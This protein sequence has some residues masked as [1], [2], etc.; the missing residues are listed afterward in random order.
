MG[1]GDRGLIDALRDA[2]GR[3]PE[4]AELRR[5]LAET[6]L[7]SGDAPAALEHARHLLG[8]DPGNVVVLDIAARAARAAGDEEAAARYAA[9]LGMQQPPA[10]RP[11]PVE[12]PRAH[13]VPVDGGD[14][15]EDEDEDDDDEPWF[16]AERPTV[17]L[18]DVG[19]MEAVKRRLQLSFLG[20]LSNP[21]LREQ[22]GAQLRGGLLLWGPPGCGKTLIARALAGE[23]GASFVSIGISDVLEMWV[24]RSEQNLRA[25]F[26]HARR[27]SPCVIFLDELDAL[28][29]K[30]SQLRH[31]GVRTTVNQLLAELDGAD[32]DND[33]LFVL[34][35]TNHPWDVDTALRRPGRFDRSVLVL[36]PDEAARVAIL[37]GALA[38]RPVASDVDVDE[39]ARR[40]ELC[41][42]ADLVHLVD[43]A[44][45]RA[46]ERAVDSGIVDPISR[47]DLRAAAKD[48]RPS[49]RPWF[50]VAKSYATFA[51]EGGEFDDLLEYVRRHRLG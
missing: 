21:R 16:D 42:G 41:S 26:D 20:P 45:E 10:T 48:T 43:G 32:R 5:H 31:S 2:L 9:A 18:D 15:D 3:E 34:G 23:L 14:E 25:A 19:G 17:R 27:L 24:G 4:N 1:G 29:Q 22:Y 7:I 38:A 39:I 49:T 47:G 33:G 37:R 44:T 51:G 30:R 28:G 13:R 36:P 40:T 35:A 50:E 12:P 8:A 11:A 6:E 46:M